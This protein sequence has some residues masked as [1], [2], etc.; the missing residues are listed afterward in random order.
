MKKSLESLRSQGN[1]LYRSEK[2]TEATEIYQKGLNMMEG[3]KLDSELVD[4]KSVFYSNQAACHMKTHKLKEAVHSCNEAIQ[5]KPLWEKPYVRRAECFKLIEAHFNDEVPEANADRLRA[6][7]IVTT[8]P[9]SYK[10]VNDS[11]KIFD[12]IKSA[13]LSANRNEIIFVEAGT[14]EMLPGDEFDWGA[15]GVSLIGANISKTVISGVLTWEST[16]RGVIKRLTIAGTL[17]N[18]NYNLIMED[19]IFRSAEWIK[20]LLGGNEKAASA[21]QWA[22]PYLLMSFNAKITMSFCY[23]QGDHSSTMAIKCNDLATLVMSNCWIDGHYRG[24]TVNNATCI[25]KNCTLSNCLLYAYQQDPRGDTNNPEPGVS[26]K[27]IEAQL[28]AF[29]LDEKA[30]VKNELIGCY[31]V[32]NNK[33]I[34]L[35]HGRKASGGHFREPV[36]SVGF[37]Q[38]E[39]ILDS[40]YIRWTDP[41]TPVLLDETPAEQ[42]F[43]NGL[44]HFGK[45]GLGRVSNCIFENFSYS[46]P[47]ALTPSIGNA[48][49]VIH[50]L[51]QFQI[52]NNKFSKCH[53]GICLDSGTT[54][55]LKGNVFSDCGQGIFIS[56][57]SRPKVTF[58]T[59]ER[60]FLAA[61]AFHSS[62]A[63]HFSKNTLKDCGGGFVIQD[64]CFPILEN[65]MYT[66][67][68]EQPELIRGPVEKE[69][70]LGF[71]YAAQ[72]VREAQEVE[73]LSGKK[74][75][76]FDHKFICEAAKENIFTRSIQ[77]KQTKK[78]RTCRACAVTS[79]EVLVCSGCQLADYCSEECQRA[80]WDRHGKECGFKI[81]KIN[82]KKEK[83]TEKNK[84]K[85]KKFADDA[86]C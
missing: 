33:R 72:V 62:G 10:K 78:M 68:V 77:D 54:S 73:K 71:Y 11:Q 35:D 52:T 84:A 22:L 59:F 37:S 45:I 34:K 9:G 67:C 76:I 2:F 20:R 64:E 17:K 57:S 53:I 29:G 26:K 19:V 30:E 15:T 58:N 1:S 14:Y 51:P 83:E 25:L 38:A 23:F 7:S 27:Q 69:H 85:T 47:S 61:V 86:T 49:M 39:S 44:R 79:S 66:N 81:K 63:G 48:G 8:A 40:C 4:L 5:V 74:I 42:Y 36:F 31:F 16:V 41:A 18:N 24:I 43:F 80:D 75:K 3:K 55:F 82:K 60:C 70:C 28:K 21:V 12:N 32:D 46:P 6:T 13:L 65:N 50:S 56:K